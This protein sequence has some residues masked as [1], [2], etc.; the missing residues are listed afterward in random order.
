MSV[1][2]QFSCAKFGHPLQKVLTFV[3]FEFTSLLAL[4]FVVKDCFT[5]CPLGFHDSQI[6]LPSFEFDL[7]HGPLWRFTLFTN[8]TEKERCSVIAFQAHHMMTDG[9][10]IQ[11]LT[12]DLEEI[13]TR[14]CN[15]E[16]NVF[17]APNPSTFLFAIKHAIAE[18]SKGID[19][20]LQLWRTKFSNAL[21]PPFFHPKCL[22]TCTYNGSAASVIHKSFAVSMT[23]IRSLC[24]LRVNLFLCLRVCWLPFT[25]SME[26]LMS[27]F[28]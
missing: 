21:L 3:S 16:A 20:Q 27:L 17:P 15:G 19:K 10:S 14:L 5:D 7:I 6:I 23:D 4:A 9:W 1:F 28:P 25:H 26:K 12:A 2:R 13:Y 8:V 11:L 18:R 22:V 24:C